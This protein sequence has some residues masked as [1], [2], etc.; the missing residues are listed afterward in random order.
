MNISVDKRLFVENILTPA[1][2][3]AENICIE[4]DNNKLKTFVSSG[5]NSIMLISNIDCICSENFKFIIP[6]TKTFIRLFSGIE[7]SRINFTITDNVVSYSKSVFSFKY[8]LLDETYISSKRT[9]SEDKLEQIK[10]ATSFTVHKTKF[11]EILKYNSIIPD[12]EKLY[13]LTTSDG[14]VV[15]RVGDEQKANSNEVT[16]EISSSFNNEPIRTQSPIS[17]QNILLMSFSDENIDVFINHDLKIYKF[18]TPYMKY[19]VS[20]LVK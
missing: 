18:Q 13:F 6:D 10:F 15:A 9:I 4:I 5:D 3:L 12:A 16:L 7:D 20:G 11:S 8:H 19:I 14:A 2:K 1:S 17:I